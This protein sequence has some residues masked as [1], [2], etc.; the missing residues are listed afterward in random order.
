MQI[1][2]TYHLRSCHMITTPN[3]TKLT[4]VTTVLPVP[5][6][7]WLLWG[8]AIISLTIYLWP[9]GEIQDQT[10]SKTYIFLQNESGIELLNPRETC[11]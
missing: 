5:R 6:K 8:I 3:T 2:S 9:A 4:N 11:A 7:T 10:Q 1:K